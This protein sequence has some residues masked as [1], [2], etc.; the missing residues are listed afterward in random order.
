MQ[1]FVA[2]EAVRKDYR[3]Y[4]ET[5]FPV[6]DSAIKA[7]VQHLIESEKLLWQELFISLARPFRTGGHLN[8]LIA[9]GILAPEISQA[10]WGFD[11]VFAHQAAAARRIGGSAAQGHNTIIATGTGSGK[12]ESFLLP[13]VDDCLRHADE[14]GV[15]AIII[16][17]MNALANDQLERM[18]RLLAGTGITFGRYTGDTPLNDYDA[19]ERSLQRPESSPVEERYT[20]A[21]IQNDPPQI[22]LTNYVM[23]ELLLLRKH[24][25]RIFKGI[26]PRFLVLDEVHTYTGILGAEVACLVRR[27]KEH[28]GLGPGELVCVGTSAT[29]VSHGD[30]PGEQQLLAFATELFGEPF[31]A[32]ALVQEIYDEPHK[33]GQTSLHPAPNLSDADLRNFNPDQPAQVRRL[34]QRTL[35]I[36][37]ASHDATLGEELYAAIGEMRAFAELERL[38]LRPR[39]LSDVAREYGLL[40]T[41]RGREQAQLERE[42]T[43]LLL[44]GS[45]AVRRDDQG[46]I[47]PRFRPKIHQIVRSLTPLAA[48]LD[49]NCGKL[50]TDGAT[51][52]THEPPMPNARALTLG[53]CRSCG[54]DYRLA[55]FTIPDTALYDTRGKRRSAKKISIQD[56]GDVVLEAE[57]ELEGRAQLYLMPKPADR[58]VLQDDEEADEDEDGEALL[59][60]F[61]ARD[62][63]VCPSCLHAR[64]DDGD[65]RCRNTGCGAYQGAQL[66]VFVAFLRG[67]KC[68]VCQA[69]GRG[70]RHEIITPLR[71]GAA[72][73][74]S[75]LTQSLLPRLE[76][77]PDGGPGEKRLLIFADSRQ[78]T[79]QQAGYLRD[80]YQ[81][82]TQRQVVY[83]TLLKHEEAEQEPI[84][85]PDLARTVFTKTREAI[86]EVDAAN[87]L[88]DVEYLEHGFLEPETTI[89]GNQTKHIMKRLQWDLMVEFTERAASRFSLEREGLTTVVYDRLAEIAQAAVGDFAQF[90]LSSDDLATLL[91]ALLDQMRIRQAVNYGPFREFLE[92]KSTPMI[93][94]EVRPTRETR[95]PFGFAA[96][97]YHRPN[98]ATVFAW[99]NKGNPAGKRTSVF[100]LFARVMPHLQPDDV[101]KLIDQ[102]VRLLARRNFIH[103]ENIGRISVAKGKFTT[104]AYQINENLVAVT[105]CGERFRCPTCGVVRG[106]Q[107]RTPGGQSICATYRCPGQ[108][109]H[110]IPNPA[111]SFYVDVYQAP[112]IERLYPV[113][114][115]GQ[116]S[117]DERVKIEAQ[118]K[119]GRV[120]ALVCTP[121]MELGVDIGDLSALLMRNIPPTPSNYAQR[122]GRAGR[123]R[124]IALILGHAGQG[125]HD[126]YFFQ[127]PDEMITGAIRPPLFMLDNQVVIDR[128][129]NSLILEKLTSTVPDDWAEIR[130][131]DGVLREDV[132]APFTQ[133]LAQRGD[134][135][136]QAVATAFVRDR[137]TGGLPWLTPE[138]VDGRVGAFVGGLRAGLEH[139][140]RR[141]REIFEELR[142]SRQKIVPNKIEQEREKR[143]TQSLFALEKDRRYYPLSY[144][145]QVGFL[146]RYGFSGDIVS[147]RYDKENQLSQA[148]AVGI[149]EYAP[150][151]IVYVSGRKVQVRRVYFRGGSREDPTANAATYRLCDRCSYATENVLARDCPHCG[152]SLRSARYIEYEGGRGTVG[153]A[154]TQEDENRSRE[155]YDV[156]TYLRDNDGQEPDPQDQTIVYDRWV[157]DYSRRRIIELYNKGLRGAAGDVQT[158]FVVC[159]ECGCWHN[160]RSTAASDQDAGIS[161]HLPRCSVSTWDPDNS[162]RIIHGL[163]LRAS[164][165]GDVIEIK[166]PDSLAQNEA[167]IATFAQA[168]KLGMQ[169]QLY[170]G[171]QEISWFVSYTYT[172]KQPHA[173][174]ILYDTMPGGTGYL[175]RAVRS[176]PQIARLVAEHLR[177]CDC[178]RACYRCL[179][180]FWNQR[181]HA[182]LDKRLVLNTLDQLAA[183]REATH[184]PPRPAR[185]R[186]E[187]FLEE[188]FAKLLQ[189]AGLPLPTTQKVVR[190]ADGQYITRADFSYDRPPLII[191]TDGRAY[192]IDSAARVVEDLDRRNAIELSGR[193]LLEFTYRDVI[194]ESDRV[195]ALVRTALQHNLTSTRAMREAPVEYGSIPAAAQSFLTQLVER[196]PRMQRGGRLRLGDGV[197]L[198]LLAHD[199]SRGLAVVL[200]D[201]DRWV[202][203]PNVWQQDLRLHN[204][205]RLRGWRLIRVPLPW[206]GSNDDAVIAAVQQAREMI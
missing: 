125:P 62:Y 158:P 106:Y 4:I 96:T 98:V 167:W 91:R 192:H 11:T 200:V 26:K 132:L 45:A 42:V 58:D 119:S 30:Q 28:T 135:I 52:C 72:P 73:A 33:P 141:Y 108:P 109:Q 182:L 136:R 105:T 151:N 1:P 61:Q 191:Q 154:I 76:P 53:L 77:A 102:L 150:G 142:K 164:I 149:T 35:G 179:K 64:P 99:Y 43:A 184:L 185:R 20:R 112:T 32:S 93:N 199:L 14:R 144:L 140:C 187:S 84:A 110:F 75:V 138:Y 190:T 50:L 169:R 188:R 159:L 13:I 27:L 195:I 202:N 197:H 6:R 36:D 103:E 5:S 172:S 18:R 161:G 24:D 177:D 12:T 166:L 126:S 186:F 156:A 39:P 101:A 146:P 85:L 9:D 180:E 63:L 82:F 67:G 203:T 163:H 60:T 129:I 25:Q 176:L 69:Q 152:E 54:A 183:T 49:P 41:R 66:P 133:E 57:G 71:S 118:F 147:L 94:R 173:T 23:L 174:L 37:L 198:N 175:W 206:L 124:R 155:S 90:G 171:S 80:R 107:L 193:T 95:R 3:H 168:L 65:R 181:N 130:T 153:E 201:P 131:D 16:Y 38:L 68:P 178:E 127:H 83:Q 104:K 205:A 157:F 117:N 196:D 143:L 44:L 170:V 88:S 116:L 46:E 81:V 51:V 123:K 165:Q 10:D 78:D 145:A 148:A 97:K 21:E 113:E 121:T 79:A 194:A 114:H 120:N 122:A 115:S 92:W 56:I 89:G 7:Q 160:P 55:A 134:L 47:L 48:C 162:D 137:D 111:D 29:I 74:V 31:D 189:A 128:H 40:E 86:G 2:A 204:W 34:T 15:R 17:P 87:L 139:W 22:L 70:R 19:A 59:A 100:D 8:D